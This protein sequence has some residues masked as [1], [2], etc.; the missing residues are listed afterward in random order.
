M[1]KIAE[2]HPMKKHGAAQSADAKAAMMLS[3]MQQ[4]PVFEGEEQKRM[5]LT[6]CNAVAGAAGQQELCEVIGRALNGFFNMKGYFL[7]LI[8]ENE[9]TSY[10]FQGSSTDLKPIKN[11]QNS[12]AHK[13][14]LADGIAE[15]V[16]NSLGGTIFHAD[17][18]FQRESLSHTADS[19]LDSVG[20]N[21]LLGT[22]LRA[23]KKDIGI[24]WTDSGMI[25]NGL[26]PALSSQISLALAHFLAVEK[27]QH[28]AAEIESL[29]ARSG[30][31]NL[32]DRQ[33][34]EPTD[35]DG[36]IIGTSAPM[37]AV[38]QMVS[39]VAQTQSTV[40]LLGET[41]TG[42]ELIAKAIH[43]ASLRKDKLM[44]TVNCAAL[45]VDLIESELF[46]HEKGSFTGA[47]ERRIGKW[48]LADQGTLF[49]DEI[50]EMPLDLQVKILR[51]LQEKEIERVGG[52]TPV[53]TDVRVIAATNRNLQKDVKHGSFRSDLFF[54]L[55]VFPILLPPL[56][57]RKQDIAAL[58][59]HFL[60]KYA[61]KSGRK[62]VQ[63]SSNVLKQ[64]GAYHW[65]GNIRELEH[66]IERSVL[67]TT[68]PVIR[69]LHLP[70][71]VEQE[72]NSI[73]AAAKIKTIAQVEKEYIMLVL[74]SCNG[75]IAGPG[76]AAAALGI[77]PT[78]L[79]SKIKKLGITKEYAG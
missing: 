58:A 15:L 45:P 72:S 11:S 55:N 43:Q 32:H 54:R 66:L 69:Q 46:G 5:F 22:V 70:E 47:I 25:C 2:S 49:L 37:K 13:L 19:F 59:S 23:A 50:G 38:M 74:K 33:A 78:T 67:L 73:W 29:R 9:T 48:E 27:M 31:Q 34:V 79:N 76:G 68:G 1:A 3:E 65:P 64:L 35:D 41:G 17:R 8:K 75:K 63:I 51:A 57:E 30:A 18:V 21:G 61:E 4:H 53:K 71:T 39:Q 16:L 62:I 20:E 40:L 28:L 7:S 6:F 14:V 56:R 52:K 60:A 42:K 10:F 26:M 44:I 12:W 24:L 77:P 36:G